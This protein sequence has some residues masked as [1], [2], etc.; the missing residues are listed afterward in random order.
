MRADRVLLR[1]V[2]DTNVYISAFVVS[3]SLAEEA[4]N[5][6]L[7]RRCELFVSVP[8]LTETALKLRGKFGWD[9][10]R[11]TTALKHISH[12]ATVVKP[13]IRINFLADEPDNRILECAVSAGANL[14]VPGD[15]HLLALKAYEDIGI[16]RIGG[17]LATV[18]KQGYI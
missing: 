1:V 12:V 11:I 2:F 18:G 6:A 5:A 4:Y 14:I 8:I 17:F 7:D 10:E 3:G 9:D 16:A 15:K 13:S